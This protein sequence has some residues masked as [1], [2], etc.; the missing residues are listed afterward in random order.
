MSE[1]LLE[2]NCSNVFLGHSPKAKEI[3]AKTNKWDLVK[4]KSFCTAKETIKKQKTKN[5]KTSYR[6]G[7]N[8]YKWSNQKGLN[9]QNIQTSHGAVYQKNKQKT[10]KKWAKDLSI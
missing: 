9:L 1:T 6:M 5:K 2:T 8:H 4:L 7:E 10:I 3:E